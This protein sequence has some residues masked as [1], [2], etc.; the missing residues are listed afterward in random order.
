[1]Q[2]EKMSTQT[3]TSSAQ[4][5]IAQ[6][7]FD[8]KNVVKCS[9]CCSLAGFKQNTHRPLVPSVGRSETRH[10]MDKLCQ[11][12]SLNLCSRACILLRFFRSFS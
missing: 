2:A 9:P 5:K 6:Q 1:M 4:F 10:F 7:E 11:K 3:C 12:V 8:L